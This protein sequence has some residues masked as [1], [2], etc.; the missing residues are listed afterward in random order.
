MLYKIIVLTFTVLTFI[1][2]G[3]D[4]KPSTFVNIFRDT[5][6][7]DELAGCL[8]ETPIDDGATITVRADK[9][10]LIDFSNGDVSDELT[11]EKILINPSAYLAK[12]ITFRAQVK[13]VQIYHHNDEPYTAWLELYTNTASA[14]FIISNPTRTLLEVE[15]NQTYDFTCRIFEVKRHVDRGGILEINATFITNTLGEIEHLPIPFW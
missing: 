13:K 6:D 2:C 3:T 12:E 10:C 4:T 14:R 15:A 9:Q 5:S 11:F 8:T 7:I 1:G